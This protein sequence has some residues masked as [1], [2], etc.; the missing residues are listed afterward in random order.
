MPEAG[1]EDVRFGLL[2][3]LLIR[4]GSG[5]LLPSPAPHGRALLATLLLAPNRPVSRERLTD[6]LWGAHPPP[7]AAASLINHVGRLRRLLGPDGGDRLRTVPAGYLVRIGRGELDTDELARAVADAAEARRAEDWRVVSSATRTALG[8]WRGAPLADLPQLADQELPAVRSFE[9]ARL[10]AAEWCFE[11]ELHLGRHE[12]AL[13]E[14]TRWAGRHP[15]H[16]ALHVHL[17]TA[18]YRSGR[19]ADALD[20]FEDIRARLAEELGV[21]PGPALRTVHQQVLRAAP[22][23]FP[24]PPPAATPTVRTPAQLPADTAD[25]TGR[26]EELATLVARL[27]ATADGRP[28]VLVVSGMGGVGKTA[29]AVHAAHRVRQSFPDGQLHVDLHGSGHAEPR[30]PHEVVARLLADLDPGRPGTAPSGHGTEPPAGP[31]A[32]TADTTDTT[33]T[34]DRSARLRSALAGRR[35]LLLLDNARDAAQVLPFLPGDGHS[36]VL[37]TSRRSLATLPDAFQVPL[38]PLDVEEQRDLLAR[39]CGG[40]RVAAEPDAA[41]RLLAAC[42]GLPLALRITSAR[43]AARPTWPL[44]VLA[45]LLAH[46]GTRLQALTAGHLSVRTTLASGYAVL[47][48]GDPAAREAARLFRLL[49][50]WPGLD[51]GAGQAAALA[52][53]PEHVTADLLE[54]LV[55]HHLLRTPEPLRYRFHELV[56]AYAAERAVAEE[57]GA[58]RDAGQARLAHWY[59]A[60]FRHAGQVL[61][62]GGPAVPGSAAD[63]PA[64]LP[65]FTDGAG[66]AAWCTRELGNATE[67]VR[68]AAASARPDLAWQVACHLAGCVTADRWIATGDGGPGPSWPVD[69]VHG[70]A[71]RF[72][73]AVEAL[74][75]SLDRAGRSGRDDLTAPVVRRLAAVHDRMRSARAV[76]ARAE[77]GG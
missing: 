11:A 29:L 51:L 17:V 50:G 70:T 59:A 46:D 60:A 24:P 63:T 67:V 14:L 2:G 56:G 41:L 47:R 77:L 30:D 48:D 66:A 12:A 69:V 35:V 37:V 32:E 73:E 28:R 31:T 33:D 4:D 13:V 38:E 76:L 55:D 26:A 42:G 21:D 64:A 23:L 39:A 36:A 25:F 62:S 44:G 43:L 15:L 27:G 75:S 8:L 57:T 10:Q 74:A 34:A 58:D 20:A 9:Q 68:R 7:S 22:V 65:V 16:E 54:T 49:G 18:L 71:D 40:E 1:G 45:D 53:R 52:D 72:S 19:Q 61:R 3:D 6:A 5:V